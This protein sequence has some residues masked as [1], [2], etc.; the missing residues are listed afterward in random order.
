MRFNNYLA[1]ALLVLLLSVVALFKADIASLSSA[2]DQLASPVCINPPNCSEQAQLLVR[3]SMSPLR[4]EEEIYVDLSLVRGWELK[5]VWIEGVNMF[6]GKNTAIIES[7]QVEDGQARAVFFLGSCQTPTM[8]WRLKT[9]W[10]KSNAVPTSSHSVSAH[11]DFY[12]ETN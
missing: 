11:F 7:R 5:K 3:F 9:E 4:T 10:Q 1:I 2:S 6:M 8:H 12:T